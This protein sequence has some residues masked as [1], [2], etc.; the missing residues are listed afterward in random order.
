ME[1]FLKAVAGI[2]V[3]L[4]LCLTLDRHSKDLSLLLSTAVCVMVI[5]AAVS[6]FRPVFDFFEKLRDIGKLD[7]DLIRVLLKSAGVGMMT[8]ISASICADGGNGALGKSVRILGTGL[9]LLLSVPVFERLL[10]LI[11]NILVMV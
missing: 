3:T 1:L 4:V 6:F 9:I 2:F 7:N 5:A 8:E 11:E 10:E